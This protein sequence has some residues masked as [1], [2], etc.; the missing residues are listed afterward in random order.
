MNDIL[1]FAISF[2]RVSVRLAGYWRGTNS[3]RVA[4]EG[5]A[6]VDFPPMIVCSFGKEAPFLT[7]R[8][9]HRPGLEETE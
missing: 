3:G 7:I 5:T 8:R 6:T 4:D 2:S 1:E 9:G